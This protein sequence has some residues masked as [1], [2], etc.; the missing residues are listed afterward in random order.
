MPVHTYI[1]IQIE[2]ATLARK[3]IPTHKIHV[4]NLEKRQ[5]STHVSQI[6]HASETMFY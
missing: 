6:L 1:N 2:T 5:Y 4:K 3:L